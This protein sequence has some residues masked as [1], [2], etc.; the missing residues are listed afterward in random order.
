MTATKWRD[1]DL[2]RHLWNLGAD[3][4]VPEVPTMSERLITETRICLAD[5]RPA[6]R[7]RLISAAAVVL[8]ALVLVPATLSAMGKP[9]LVKTILG[10]QVTLSNMDPAEW[11]RTGFSGWL[12]SPGA[13]ELLSPEETA[14]VAPFPI[15]VPTWLPEGYEAVGLPKG[16]YPYVHENGRWDIREDFQLF[17][18]NQVFRP[19][20]GNEAPVLSVLHSVRPSAKRGMTLAPG[21]QTM[22]IKGHPAFL[23]MDIP[24][25]EDSKEN[26]DRAKRGD[27]PEVVGYANQL[28]IW[29]EEPDGQITQIAISGKFP[30]EVLTR[31]GESLFD[32]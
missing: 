20:H 10:I 16:A 23:Q 28:T 14:K 2:E 7:V 27:L 19:A 15:R 5:S 22:E 6:P 24:F 8:A 18:V 25:A 12:S 26:E 30:P 1:E 11:I 9:G 4:T 32:S 17:Y 31:V 29:V 3:G 21:T 13:P